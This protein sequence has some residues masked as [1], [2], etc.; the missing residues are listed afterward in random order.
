VAL[1][2]CLTLFIP[3]PAFSD[4]YISTIGVDFKIQSIKL[5]GATVKLQIWDT[6]GQVKLGLLDRPR[7]S[8]LFIC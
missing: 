3:F 8:D 6:A 2:R 5:D 7:I 1:Y 4:S